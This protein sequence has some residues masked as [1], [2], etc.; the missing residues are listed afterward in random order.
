MLLERICSL[1]GMISGPSLPAD[2]TNLPARLSLSAAGLTPHEHI[3]RLPPAVGT[4]AKGGRWRAPCA[5]FAL[6]TLQTVALAPVQLAC[7]LLAR[8]FP[9]WQASQW[10]MLRREHAEMV[11]ADSEVR[12]QGE[13]CG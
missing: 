9:S 2:C 13:G 3:R 11:A 8:L 12:Q 4:L 6:P 7:Q 1:P 10:F 5:C